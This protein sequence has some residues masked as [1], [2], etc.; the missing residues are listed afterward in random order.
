MRSTLDQR[1]WGSVAQLLTI[2][3]LAAAAVS[4]FRRTLKIQISAI[5][6]SRA[7]IADMDL[8]Q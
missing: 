1:R 6:A 8:S 7:H 2:G 4:L 5:T 3:A